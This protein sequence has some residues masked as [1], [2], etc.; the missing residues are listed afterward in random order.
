M[1]RRLLVVP[2]TLLVLFLTADVGIVGWRATLRAGPG[3]DGRPPT[4]GSELPAACRDVAI[5]LADGRNVSISGYRV[6]PGSIDLVLERTSVSERWT[7]GGAN[8]A[9][10][11]AGL[12]DLRV[13]D[14]S[15]RVLGRYSRE[16]LD[17]TPSF[18]LA[19]LGSG[20]VGV[21]LLAAGILATVHGESE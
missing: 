14:R 20:L 12:D 21:G 11:L 9:D 1:D 4:Y 18:G 17:R 8:C 19:R 6:A 7:L 16:R 2:G 10:R 5:A 15:Y 13:D 3:L